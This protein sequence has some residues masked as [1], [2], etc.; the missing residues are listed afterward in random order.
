MS[1]CVT[2]ATGNGSAPTHSFS[3]YS[4]NIPFW[5]VEVKPIVSRECQH[6][7]LLSAYFLVLFFLA[8][9]HRSALPHV[10]VH[11]EPVTMLGF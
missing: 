6:S 11:G 2:V 1:L 5:G 9:F 10:C 8:I 4:L 7:K 3:P